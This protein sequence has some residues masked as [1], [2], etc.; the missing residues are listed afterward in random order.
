MEAL[1]L[2][3]LQALWRLK[4]LL[5]LRF[6]NQRD[7]VY[8][9]TML[10]SVLFSGIVAITLGMGI[11]WIVYILA[12]TGDSRLLGPEL[13]Q[14][15][16]LGVFLVLS[17]VWML[18]PLLFIMKNESLTL[19]VSRLTRYPIAYRTLHSFH[20]L[21]ALLDPWT[22]FY[23]PLVLGILLAVI[24]R[25]G[26]PLFAPVLILLLLWVLVHTV[27]SR[28]LQ[29]LI[30]VLFTSRHLREVLSLGAIVLVILIAFVPAMIT[31]QTSL[32]EL[33]GI[34]RGTSGQVLNLE[35][36]LFQW[37]TWRL[38][39]PLMTLL[40]YFT[41]AGAFVH[42]LAGLLYDHWDW[43]IQ[44]CIALFC[45]M[46]LANFLGIR[47][48]RRLFT[49]PAE[50][51]PVA[52]GLLQSQARWRLPLLP[53]D[54]RVLVLKE[55][56]TYFR[57]ILGKLSFFLTPMLAVVLRL[58]GL[59]A[60]GNY[61]PASLLLGMTIYVFMTSLFLYI[62][63]FGSD[64]EGFK[65]YLLSGIAPR[66]LILAK[67]LALGLFSGAEFAIVLVLFVLLYRRADADT[68]CFGIG[69][70]VFMLMGVL[71]LGNILS[72]RFAAAMDL[73]QTQYRQS[74]G[75]PILLALQVLS[76]LTASAGIALWLATSRN[77]PL[78]PVGLTLAALMTLAWRLLLPFSENL[79]ATQ[80]LNILDQVTKKE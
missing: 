7:A 35:L 56:R 65:L 68:I 74:N 18:S 54:I 37:P 43:W 64:G 67:N 46:A 30:S 9:W 15:L 8:R 62:N 39:H 51:M 47:L 55:L 49:E 63:Y 36:I 72:T 78:W 16:W 13:L 40:L 17:L 76:M 25:G 6:W 1:T 21:L 22:L 10:F 57:S 41:P 31:E 2:R 20:T 66:R 26:S 70:F 80:S 5:L 53:Y 77:E 34:F 45:W 58:I 12:P 3:Q 14:Y 27:W 24:A 50:S 52:G 71:A 32:E 29:D 11:G 60:S 42:A 73:N 19:D 4:L 79:L 61:A 48:L 44:G 33:A 28:L 38:L 69:A 59:G 23:Y 75:T